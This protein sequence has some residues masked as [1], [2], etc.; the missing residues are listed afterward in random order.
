MGLLSAYVNMPTSM[1][2]ED[3]SFTLEEKPGAYIWVGNGTFQGGRNLY[4][5]KYNSNDEGLMVGV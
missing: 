2:T 1:G 4:G 3:F 5:P